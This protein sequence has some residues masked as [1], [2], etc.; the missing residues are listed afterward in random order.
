MAAGFAARGHASIHRRASAAARSTDCVHPSQ[1]FFFC[2]QV[3]LEPDGGKLQLRWAMD[4]FAK[5]FS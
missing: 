5:C 3:A 2:C 4:V 1:R